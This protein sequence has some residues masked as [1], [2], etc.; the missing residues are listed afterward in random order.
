MSKKLFDDV[1][2]KRF[3]IDSQ[4]QPR[5]EVVAS[6]DRSRFAFWVN[7]SSVGGKNLIR[8]YEIETGELLSE[9]DLG[10]NVPGSQGICFTSDSSRVCIATSGHEDDEICQIWDVK[11][12]SKVKG[13]KSI[14]ST[15]SY[16]QSENVAITHDSKY[17][18]T[19][20][21]A[22]AMRMNDT[23]TG[24]PI[25]YWVIAEHTKDEI[26]DKVPEFTDRSEMGNKPNGMLTRIA[27]SP[28][29]P[30]MAM[31]W[32]YIEK[33][34]Y[35]CV[36]E[37]INVL[38]D[39]LIS[40]F[41]LKQ[42]YGVRFLRFSDDGNILELSK[43]RGA[44]E[45]LE[46]RTVE[47]GELL[48]S[49]KVVNNGVFSL[50]YSDDK[51]TLYISTYNVTSDVGNYVTYELDE[52]TG[53]NIVLLPQGFLTKDR[54]KLASCATLQKFAIYDVDLNKINELITDTESKLKDAPKFPYD[55]LTIPAPKVTKDIIKK[56]ANKIRTKLKE[57]ILEIPE[58]D[59][60]HKIAEAIKESSAILEP[61]ENLQVELGT[62]EKVANKILELYEAKPNIPDIV[63][64]QNIDLYRNEME[65]QI[66]NDDELIDYYKTHKQQLIVNPIARKAFNSYI[67]K[68]KNTFDKELVEEVKATLNELKD[69]P[70]DYHDKFMKNKKKLNKLGKK[71]PWQTQMEKD[72]ERIDREIDKT[73]RELLN[74]VKEQKKLFADLS[75]SL[76]PLMA[77]LD[78][79][80]GF[81]NLII[82]T[83]QAF[84]TAIEY[85]SLAHDGLKTLMV[86]NRVLELESKIKDLVYKKRRVKE[87]TLINPTL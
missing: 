54:T 13:I 50:D 82:K 7:P 11:S 69:K 53:L 71:N 22:F 23:N 52:K 26:K 79:N 87:G 40:K 17:V 21:G 46:F 68:N 58:T 83:P 8:I 45:M 49:Y 77:P 9:L 35:N 61:I 36:V 30:L 43:Q 74:L 32:S 86:T 15:D 19:V 31:V 4:Y 20:G 5:T 41:E 29:G 80:T 28:K 42:I 84:A 72:I 63:I 56:S 60:I 3:A 44:G 2:K 51:N 37:I 70:L 14:S 25:R 39:E 66:G 55:K 34:L 18:I 27:C 47:K 81:I 62:A 85:L 1:L 10:K 73:A 12:G 38:T 78:F 67:I 33:P 6:P 65:R 76:D 57:K 16:W 59:D 75:K 64:E 48:L 24:D